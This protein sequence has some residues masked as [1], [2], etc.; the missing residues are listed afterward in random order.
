MDSQTV[1]LN[2]KLFLEGPAGAGKTTRG[3]RYV[4]ALL[5]SGVV[6]DRVLVLVPQV[7]YER[8]YQ[9]A[10]AESGISGGTVEITT[11]AGIARRAVETYWPSIAEP[12]G[13][14][15]PNREPIFLNVETAQYYMARIA[16]PAIRAGQFNA[17]N[18]A[19]PR[20]ILQVLDYLQKAAML[21]CPLDEVAQ[22]LTNAWADR[23]SSRPPV[24]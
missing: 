18:I 14:A 3:T 17:V 4:R 16:A 2:V 22:R 13:F 1:D 8:P 11:L 21:R 19:P 10:V 15:A 23:H 24:Y 5:D 9:L 20:L 7:T 12:M 6:P